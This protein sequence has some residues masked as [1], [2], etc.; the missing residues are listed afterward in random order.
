MRRARM[1]FI[2]RIDDQLANPLTRSPDEDRSGAT[3]QIC[4]SL[5]CG[6][7]TTAAGLNLESDR[8]NLELIDC[9]KRDPTT[10]GSSRRIVS[11][12]VVAS[13]ARDARG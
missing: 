6:S 3:I 8:F 7:V 13:V 9:R 5:V 1:A 4:P 10:A 11:S 12:I 2:E